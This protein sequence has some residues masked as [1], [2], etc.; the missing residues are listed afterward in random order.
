M[1]DKNNLFLKKQPQNL[2]NFKKKAIY[3]IYSFQCNYFIISYFTTSVV[4]I[5]LPVSLFSFI[6]Y[7]PL[8]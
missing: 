5:L 1:S 4:V 7:T 6:K 2:L 3:N 8:G